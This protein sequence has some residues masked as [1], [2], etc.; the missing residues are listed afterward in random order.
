[1]SDVFKLNKTVPWH[2]LNRCW[3]FE[4][5]HTLSRYWALVPCTLSRECLEIPHT[6]V[7]DHE[8][9][10]RDRDLGD[11]T[12]TLSRD[13]ASEITCTLSRDNY[14]DTTHLE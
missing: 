9:R 11:T 1:M 8:Y 6:F 14:G 4:I 3:T 2:T 7:I 13:W 10:E 5:P 12:H